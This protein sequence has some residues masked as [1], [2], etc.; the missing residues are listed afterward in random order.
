[1]LPRLQTTGWQGTERVRSQSMRVIL[2]CSNSPMVDVSCPPCGVCRSHSRCVQSPRPCSRCC[3][4]GRSHAQEWRTLSPWA[5][6]ERGGNRVR[7]WVGG[8]VGV[9][10]RTE[11][12]GCP[13]RKVACF[14]VDLLA[15]RAERC[16]QQHV[17]VGVCPSDICEGGSWM[18]AAHGAAGTGISETCFSETHRDWRHQNSAVI[19]SLIILPSCVHAH[20]L[21][22]ASDDGG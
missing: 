21:P 4:R 13:V 5:V 16:E 6:H 1:M 17:P 22:Q 7:G 11:S 10:T 12:E 18:S 2:S 3:R 14:R 15:C 19:R 20:V 8:R 9:L